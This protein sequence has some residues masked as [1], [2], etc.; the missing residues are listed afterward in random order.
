MERERLITV[1]GIGTLKIPVDFIE[2]EFELRELNKDYEQG[3]SI[4]ENSIYDLQKIITSL[5]F[6]KENLKTSEVDVK[7]EYDSI[8]KNGNYVQIFKGYIF[9]CELKLRF[10]LD[11]KKLAEL[12]KAV[13]KSKAKPR[14]DI[15]FTVKDK[16]AVKKS[17]LAASA[18][19]AR[20]KADILCNAMGV[21][22]GNL[23]TINYNWEEVRIYSPTRLSQHQEL[24][25]CGAAPIDFT[26]DDIDVTDDASFVWEITD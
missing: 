20:E 9:D 8:K 7:P 10:D 12:L 24:C 14:I 22:L 1:K 13:S 15:E 17:L 3:Y 25:C 16:E 21:K 2:V 6:D 18:K 19:D 26:P 4:F 23:L 11:S 5:G